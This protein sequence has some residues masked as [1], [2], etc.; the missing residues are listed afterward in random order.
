MIF[1]FFF[2][3]SWFFLSIN[4][5]NNSTSDFSSS[6]T[7]Y[8]PD[9]SQRAV[10]LDGLFNNKPNCF[11]TKTL[12]SQL[13]SSG[14]V[15]DVFNGENVTIDLFRNL[16][17]YKI[18]VLRVHSTI[19]SDRFLYLFSGEPYVED[20]YVAEQLFGGVREAY[21]FE[22]N[23][24]YFALKAIFL[25]ERIGGLVNSI[26]VL[27]GCNGTGHEYTLNRLLDDG[28]EK[29]IAWDGY[30][31]LAHSDEAIVLLFD[32]MFTEGLSWKESVAKVNFIIEE[33]FGSSLK[34]FEK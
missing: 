1:S 8:S 26:V 24:S 31:D 15:T 14:F 20:K 32:Y 3:I 7:S 9:L 21:P 19:H 13:E 6:E 23:S 16:Q 2:L 12:C 11:F 4:H 5:P 25:G 30:V 28:V 27:M 33:P 22:E 17:H 34:L 18:V 29:V 10:L